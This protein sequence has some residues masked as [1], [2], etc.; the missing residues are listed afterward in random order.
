MI[1]IIMTIECCVHASYR[2]TTCAPTQTLRKS[3]L[4]TDDT[5][6]LWRCRRVSLS[7]AAEACSSSLF[8]RPIITTA[9]SPATVVLLFYPAPTEEGLLSPSSLSVSAGTRRHRGLGT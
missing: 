2:N 1:S 5:I 9:P 4:V 7:E 3:A 8:R 6:Y